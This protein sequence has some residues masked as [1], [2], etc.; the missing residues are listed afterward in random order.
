M[1]MPERFWERGGKKHGK[2]KVRILKKKTTKKTPKPQHKTLICARLVHTQQKPKSERDV[3][4]LLRSAG[5]GGRGS[6]FCVRGDP[7]GTSPPRRCASPRL[8]VQHVLPPEGPQRGQEVEAGRRR[9]G[10][11]GGV[12]APPSLP[13]EPLAPLALVS[14]LPWCSF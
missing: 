10:Q 6:R 11:R 13:W 3:A 2:S 8:L 1:A 7:G 5:T 4:G 14:S 12:P 9:G